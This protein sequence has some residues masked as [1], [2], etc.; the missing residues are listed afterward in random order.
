MAEMPVKFFCKIQ[1]TWSHSILMDLSSCPGNEG[2]CT[3]QNLNTTGR[4]MMD[5]RV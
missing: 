3:R 1:K 2:N 5:G 4:K